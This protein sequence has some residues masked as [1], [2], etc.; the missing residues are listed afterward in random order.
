MALLFAA[1]LVVVVPVILILIYMIA[2]GYSVI[3]WDFY[4]QAPSQAGKAGGIF[5]AIVGTLYLMLG[6]III[7]PADRSA[8]RYLPFGI[9][10]RQLADAPDQPG[11]H[12]PGRGAQ[13]SSS[14]CSA[15]RSSC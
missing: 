14:A 15:W 7:C 13:S 11:D 4:H 2:S 12:Q 3:N 8:G 9:R 5:P 6:T 10:P 1:M